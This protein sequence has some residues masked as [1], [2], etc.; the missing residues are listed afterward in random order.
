MKPSSGGFR[1][2]FMPVSMIDV[3]PADE[4]FD[5]SASGTPV[6]VNGPE[7]PAQRVAQP[8]QP[9][10]GVFRPRTSHAEPWL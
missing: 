3:G 8:G 2:R 7:R 1:T 4:L 5:F 10:E 6:D 9:R